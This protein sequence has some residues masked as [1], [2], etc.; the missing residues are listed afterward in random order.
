MAYGTKPF[1]KVTEKILA[2]QATMAT[3]QQL[4]TQLSVAVFS[5][6][7]EWGKDSASTG[8]GILASQAAASPNLA[9]LN[10]T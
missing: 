7:T 10:G 2:T 9:Q 1:L 6:V 8:I 4:L 3:E 5:Q